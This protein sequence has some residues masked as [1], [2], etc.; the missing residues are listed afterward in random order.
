MLVDTLILLQFANVGPI[1][2]N[3]NG[4][5]LNFRDGQDPLQNAKPA[6]S[7]PIFTQK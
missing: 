5:T 6:G 4:Q 2:P 7:G 3:A 1:V